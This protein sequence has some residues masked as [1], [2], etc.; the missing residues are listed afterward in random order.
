[1]T[2][3]LLFATL[4]LVWGATWLAIK[5]GLSESPPFYGAALRFL[6][7]W[8]VLAVLVWKGKRRWP[9]GRQVWMWLIASGLAM[10]FG[11]YA[12]VY[13][14]EQYIDS[15]LAAIL[16]ASYPFFVAIGAHFHIAAERLSPLKVAG[17]VIGFVGVVV[18][19]GGSV[20]APGT[21]AWWAPALMLASPFASAIASIIVKRHLTGEDP[22]VLNCVQMAIGAVLLFGAAAAVEDFASFHWNF[23][24]VGALLFLALFGSAYAFVTLYH[25]MRTWPVTRLSLIAFITPVVATVLGWLVLHERLSWATALG[26]LLVFAGIWMVNVLAERGRRKPSAAVVSEFPAEGSSV[27][28]R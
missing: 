21:G 1:M 19:F 24:S 15:A 6:I 11:S 7:A 20:T 23:T 28:V 8:A 4:C 14:V 27:R 10:Y 13:Y 12:V 16:F 26:A 18:V 9:R 3:I 2:N 25:L 5:I 22:I 17:L